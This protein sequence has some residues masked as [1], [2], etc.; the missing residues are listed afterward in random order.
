MG[1]FNSALLILQLNSA[2]S[3]VVGLASGLFGIGGIII[4]GDP[5]PEAVA[6]VLLEDNDD[7]DEEKEEEDDAME[8]GSLFSPVAYRDNRRACFPPR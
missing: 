8:L 7:D 6:L 3:G 1:V 2:C 4:D 5:I